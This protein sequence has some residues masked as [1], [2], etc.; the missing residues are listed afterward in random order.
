MTDIAPEELRKLCEAAT[1]GP[2]HANENSVPIP[3]VRLEY[4]WNEEFQFYDGY[5]G[6]IN[7]RADGE[8]IAAARTA[9]PQ[10]LDTIE[11]LKARIAELEAVIVT[12]DDLECGMVEIAGTYDCP[13]GCDPDENHNFVDIDGIAKVT[14]LKCRSCGRL[15]PFWDGVDVWEQAKKVFALE[16][17]LHQWKSAVIHAAVVHWTYKAEHENDPR[18]AINALMCDAQQIAL[19][20]CVSPE[21]KALHDKIHELENLVNEAEARANERGRRIVEL[22]QQL[23]KYEESE[24]YFECPRC[25]GLHFGSS[26]D[27]VTRQIV[28]V[29]CHDEYSKGC[30]WH[31]KWPLEGGDV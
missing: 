12:P 18:A 24:P 1:P 28:E 9:V 16:G 14:H 23:A 11:R 8:F 3:D 30:R 25:G 2:W 20:P 21:A 26:L 13:C 5:V 27:P 15:K 31:G 6:K 22:E 7:E 29:F 17:E 19:D 10:L 4:G